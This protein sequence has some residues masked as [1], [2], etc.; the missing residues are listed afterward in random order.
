MATRSEERDRGYKLGRRGGQGKLR[1]GK[2]D[3]QGGSGEYSKLQVE[4]LELDIQ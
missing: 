1:G 3:N 4:I 2:I